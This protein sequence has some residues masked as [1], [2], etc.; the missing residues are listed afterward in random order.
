[1]GYDGYDRD[2]VGSIIVL[3]IPLEL[4][5]ESVL[6]PP[7]VLLSDVD[8]PAPSRYDSRDEEVGMNQETVA[9]NVSGM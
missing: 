4:G 8:E 6:V 5:E 9:W 7:R 1:M 2:D 3:A